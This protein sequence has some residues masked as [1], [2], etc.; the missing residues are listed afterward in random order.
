MFTYDLTNSLYKII[1]GAHKRFNNLTTDFL[2]NF[3]K[4]IDEAE[5]REVT[6]FVDY[7]DTTVFDYKL[8]IVR[9]MFQH[10]DEIKAQSRC[11]PLEEIKKAKLEGFKCTYSKS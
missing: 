7:L 5:K 11:E 9:M 6:E 10:Y 8:R 2:L 3:P 4:N 1:T